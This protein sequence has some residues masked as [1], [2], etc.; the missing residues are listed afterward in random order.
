MSDQDLLHRLEALEFKA[1]L[2]M[3]LVDPGRDPFVFAM[4]E[5]DA[6]R[7]QV[8]RTYD[9]LDDYWRK[10]KSNTETRNHHELESEV[11]RIF[12]TKRGDYHFAESIVRANARAG[13][14]RELYEYLRASGMNFEP[15]ESLEP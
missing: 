5:A 8:Q 2:L 3:E 14:Y 11:Y 9:L 7:N 1:E 6:T 13:R 12:P 4:L 15:F 10:V